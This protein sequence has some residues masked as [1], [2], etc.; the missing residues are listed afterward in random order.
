MTRHRLFTIVDGDKKIVFVPDLRKLYLVPSGA[1]L[2]EYLECDSSETKSNPE[3]QDLKFRAAHLIVNNKCNLRCIYCYANAGTSRLQTMPIEIATA[4]ISK[5]AQDAKAMGFPYFEISFIG[6]EPTLSMPLIKK[7][8]QFARQVAADLGIKVGI[9]LVSNGVFSKKVAEY[10]VGNFNYIT[11]SLDGPEEIQNAQ[12]PMTNGKGSF[13]K[14][15]AN[16]R[17]IYNAGLTMGL[18]CTVS[19]LSVKALPEIVHFLHDQFP[20]A[21]IG[22]EPLQE[23]G[24][25][26]TTSTFSPEPL[27]YAEKLISTLKT[28][29]AENIKIKSSILRFKC[30]DEQ[31]SFCGANGQ[32][33]AVNP[34]GYVT[35][36]T[37]VTTVDDP[38][39]SIFYF[40]RYDQQKNE[41]TFDLSRYKWLK[42]LV[43]DSIPECNDCFARFNCKGDCPIIKSDFGSDFATS[44]SQ[45]CEAIKAITLGLF[46]LQLG[47]L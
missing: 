3:K 13:Q 19:A 30:Q 9:G 34:E 14:V 22:I 16:V 43:V 33:F 6:G 12:R 21:R 26:L 2:P 5:V 31:I 25:C 27:E 40:G 28:V 32:N 44:R 35:A 8:I 4:A 42:S 24:R 39:S 23:C 15:L 38:K 10:I 29:A 20:K 45:K 11:F 17:Y 37:R 36:C 7:A 41:F 18:R 1:I 46:K 47:I